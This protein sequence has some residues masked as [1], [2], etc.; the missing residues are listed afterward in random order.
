MS[1]AIV[2][3]LISMSP[4][5]SGMQLQ[6]TFYA[7]HNLVERSVLS[8]LVNNLR[9]RSEPIRAAGVILSYGKRES[10]RPRGIQMQ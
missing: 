5:L 6:T 1:R 10:A 3:T 8:L 9:H 2:N 7:M 4:L